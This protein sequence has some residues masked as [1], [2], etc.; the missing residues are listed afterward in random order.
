MGGNWRDVP[1]EE[2]VI[3]AENFSSPGPAESV[4]ARYRGDWQAGSLYNVRD[5]VTYVG[6]DTRLLMLCLVT[7]VA[8]VEFQPDNWGLLTNLGTF[9]GSVTEEQLQAALATVQAAQL[10]VEIRAAEVSTT[11]TEVDAARVQA[12]GSATLA[13]EKVELVDKM[14]TLP[15]GN[16][17]RP[18]QLSAEGLLAKQEALLSDAPAVDEVTIGDHTG[19]EGANGAEQLF[20]AV[21]AHLNN[22]VRFVRAGTNRDA[23]YKIPPSL[24]TQ[25][26]AP[27]KDGRYAYIDV[28]NDMVAGNQV[29]IEGT[30]NPSSSGSVTLKPT[31]IA[32]SSATAKNTNTAQP[33]TT[34]LV[35]FTTGAGNPIPAGSNRKFQARIAVVYHVTPT[36]APSF[37][38]PAGTA[39]VVDR[40]TDGGG[41][42]TSADP[43]H[44][45]AWTG[46]IS[47]TGEASLTFQFPIQAGWAAYYCDVVVR[48]NCDGFEDVTVL[49]VD[50]ATSGSVAATVEPAT[51]GA[52]VDVLALFQGGATEGL[53]LTPGTNL[54]LASTGAR[55][56]KDFAYARQAHDDR[57]A[58]SQ[59]YTGVVGRNTPRAIIAMVSKPI[60]EST[61]GGGDD[62]IR[63]AA[64]D[65]V[66]EPG[67]GALLQIRNDGLRVFMARY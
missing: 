51:A 16:E 28:Y 5:M 44:I 59:A 54:R 15:P 13:T 48:N 25:P 7:H 20:T 12:Q 62:N 14:I 23:K 32:E 55:T 64:V 9:G 67:Q 65:R 2:P 39:N 49:A 33:A 46:D 60:V 27:G 29:T 4:L 66:L 3:V 63:P 21:A 34:V 35:P 22:K 52:A 37:T 30:G 19:E 6:N 57:P 53:G 40:G 17:W 10:E 58:A 50:N 11:A 24:Y 36:T 43:L 31:R 26:S 8:Q 38:A 42:P 18:G 56:Q 41:G 47:G 1:S 45:R 61:G